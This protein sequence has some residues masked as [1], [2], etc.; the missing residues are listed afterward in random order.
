[1]ILKKYFKKFIKT[2][3]FSFLK[4]YHYEKLNTKAMTK[5][6]E[7]WYFQRAD[8]GVNSVLSSSCSYHF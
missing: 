2:L 1:M 6:D 4:C 3:D 7:V 5:T 8:V